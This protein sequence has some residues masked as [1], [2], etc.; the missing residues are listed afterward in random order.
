MRFIDLEAIL[1]RI[2]NFLADLQVAQDAALA[3]P[4][5]KRRARII[6]ANQQRCLPNVY[7]SMIFVLT[8]G[9]RF[10]R[11]RYKVRI[12]GNS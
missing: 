11:S 6:E 4:N 7:G 2:R 10:A 9:F 3:E 12:C 8:S 1:P 5:A